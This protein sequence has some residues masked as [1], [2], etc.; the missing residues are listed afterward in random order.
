MKWVKMKGNELF[1]RDGSREDEMIPVLL[2]MRQGGK[3]AFIV[4]DGKVNP[5]ITVSLE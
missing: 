5:Y 4:I 1:R 2:A 3:S